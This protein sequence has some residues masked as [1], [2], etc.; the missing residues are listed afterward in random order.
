MGLGRS[1]E[2]GGIRGALTIHL[3]SSARGGEKNG[4]LH[5]F[6]DV[7]LGNGE[8]GSN[9]QHPAPETDWKDRRCPDVQIT[10]PVASVVNS[11]FPAFLLLQR[12]IIGT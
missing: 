1:R 11:D 9:I 6:R 3:A 5:S 8:K 12:P 4:A 7:L 2:K 10:F